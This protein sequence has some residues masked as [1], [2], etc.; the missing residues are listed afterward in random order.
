[1]SNINRMYA[2]PSSPFSLSPEELAEARDDLKRAEA[3]AVRATTWAHRTRA[4]QEAESLRGRIR[5][6]E[7]QAHVDEARQ[8]LNQRK[9]STLIQTAV[10]RGVAEG[11]YLPPKP[12]FAES[13]VQ[14][15]GGV[16]ELVW[17]KRKAKLL[18]ATVDDATVDVQT[19][20]KARLELNRILQRIEALEAALHPVKELGQPATAG[21]S[22]V[23][24][25]SGS[26]G[27]LG[28]A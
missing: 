19:R 14:A 18:Q 10:A 25:C 6:A 5:G 15:P 27:Q 26:K 8:T 7:L 22:A 11:K 1:M 4:E 17:L 28:G 24:L 9:P 20:T 13:E 2:V 12:Y 21:N 23:R 3:E 16:D